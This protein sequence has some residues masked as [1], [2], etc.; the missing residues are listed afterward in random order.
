M[1]RQKQA[2][3][4]ESQLENQ[5]AIQEAANKF[6]FHLS[7][8]N[9]EI[10]YFYINNGHDDAHQQEQYAVDWAEKL[11]NAVVDDPDDDPFLFNAL[12]N[13]KDSVLELSAIRVHAGHLLRGDVPLGTE[14]YERLVKADPSVDFNTDRSLGEMATALGIDKDEAAYLKAHLAFNKN[15]RK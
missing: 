10:G 11:V 6:L 9:S 7:M 8:V 14:V 13:Y 12:E 15:K 1:K 4:G 5:R 3:S 2:I